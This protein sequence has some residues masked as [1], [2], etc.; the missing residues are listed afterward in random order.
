MLAHPSKVCF[1]AAYKIDLVGFALIKLIHVI[2]MRLKV[3]VI[4]HLDIYTMTKIM[5]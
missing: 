1:K 3:I 4:R 2:Y 5:R